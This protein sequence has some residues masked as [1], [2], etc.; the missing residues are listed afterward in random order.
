MH[1]KSGFEK[2]CAELFLEI[3]NVELDYYCTIWCIIAPY[4]DKLPFFI[5]LPIV[6]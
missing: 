2:R 3:K 6:A 5:F 1:Q 4:S